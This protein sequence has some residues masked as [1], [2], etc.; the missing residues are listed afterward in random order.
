MARTE[1]RVLLAQ[2]PAPLWI[3]LMWSASLVVELLRGTR[4]PR[5]GL[6]AQIVPPRNNFSFQMLQVPVFSLSASFEGTLLNRNHVWLRKSPGK[7]K[8]TMFVLEFPPR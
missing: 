2:L 5:P 8:N 7:E 3:W 1:R 6:F 4:Q